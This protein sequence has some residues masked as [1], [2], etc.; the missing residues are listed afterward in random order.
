MSAEMTKN[1]IQKISGDNS[2]SHIQFTYPFQDKNAKESAF[3][4]NG[5]EIYF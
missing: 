3:L 5:K 4:N 1:K 2:N